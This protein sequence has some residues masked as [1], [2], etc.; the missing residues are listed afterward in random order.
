MHKTIVHGQYLHISTVIL[1]LFLVTFPFQW[2][3]IQCICWIQPIFYYVS[4][5]IWILWL[6]WHPCTVCG[7]ESGYANIPWF[8]IMSTPAELKKKTGSWNHYL[9]QVQFW[10]IHIPII[11]Y[12]IPNIS[13]YIPNISYYIPIFPIYPT[14]I[15]QQTS[16]IAH[17][18]QVW[19]PVVHETP[20]SRAVE[21]RNLSPVL[22]TPFRYSKTASAYAP[23]QSC[24]MEVSSWET[25]IELSGPISSKPCGWF[26]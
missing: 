21:P 7:T 12:N 14:L 2:V 13:D 6:L 18:L 11:S 20:L 19:W 24:T 15:L 26:S 25:S 1:R 16:R 10:R 9:G 17:Q 23:F 22:R 8:L 3:D 5:L 4:P